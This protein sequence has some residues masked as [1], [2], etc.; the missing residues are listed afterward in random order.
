LK[1]K[2]GSIVGVVVSGKGKAAL[3]LSLKS[4]GQFI[5]GHLGLEPFPG[6]LNLKVSP[7][8]KQEFLEGKM[9]L[10]LRSF[11]H[12]GKTMGG[13]T[14]YPVKVDGRVPALLVTPDK[15]THSKDIVEIVA[16]AS[17]RKGLKLRDGSKV[18]IS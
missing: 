3:F 6:T 17:L 7:K 8:E 18:V 5:A 14:A 11:K 13:I 9:K 10:R 12:E 15:T 1:K 4:Y 16:V 2:T